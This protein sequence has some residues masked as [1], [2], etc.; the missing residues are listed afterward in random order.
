MVMATDTPR[1][2]QIVHALTMLAM[3]DYHV[4]PH[5]D[6]AD[7]LAQLAR[8]AQRLVELLARLRLGRLA[9]ARWQRRELRLALAPAWF[10]AVKSPQASSGAN[11]ELLP[12]RC[13]AAKAA[14]LSMLSH[15]A[16]SIA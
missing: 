13:A 9:E 4:L 3:D 14:P 1:D 10:E 11:G 2:L 8:R 16:A 5:S 12:A 7:Q 6:R 15:S